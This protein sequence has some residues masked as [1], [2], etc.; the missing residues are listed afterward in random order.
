MTWTKIRQTEYLR[1]EGSFMQKAC[2][3]QSDERAVKGPFRWGTPNAG[4]ASLKWH[5]WAFRA[6]RSVVLSCLQVN[7]QPV[8]GQFDARGQLS[9]SVIV[10]VI[11]GQMSKISALGADPSGRR[12]SL[13]EAHM[14]RMRFA[15][16]GIEDGDLHT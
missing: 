14:R 16:Q 4:V 9:L 3:K 5:N 10:V 8:V 11:V 1:A 7:F 13:V 15:P 6:R 2:G 12:E